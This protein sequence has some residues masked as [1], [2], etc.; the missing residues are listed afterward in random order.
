MIVATED[1]TLTI[2]RLFKA[3]PERVFN[4]WLQR[5]EWQAWIGPEG[6]DCEVPLLEPHVGG[7]YRLNMHLSDGG[8]IQVTGIFQTIDPPNKLV[9]TWGRYGDASNSSVV[10]L[11]F[12]AKGEMTELTLV[13]EGLGTVANRDGHGKGWNSAL[14]KLVAYLVA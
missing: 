7:K 8:L 14:N 6:V 12:K 10:T 2:T 4:A 9:F 3:P 5:E 11:I 1:A 13:H